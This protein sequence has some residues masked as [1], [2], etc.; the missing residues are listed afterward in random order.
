MR[1]SPPSLPTFCF[2]P[3]Q[4]RSTPVSST[5]DIQQLLFHKLRDAMAQADDTNAVST[6][7][8]VCGWYSPV[9]C[10]F[11]RFNALYFHVYGLAIIN[12]EYPHSRA[13]MH[14]AG[15]PLSASHHAMPWVPVLYAQT[16][17]GTE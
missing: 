1:L 12:S 4:A 15:K 16:H 9:L 17:T 6:I 7:L 10:A 8:Q 11:I 13:H 5:E 2:A 14:L 3:T